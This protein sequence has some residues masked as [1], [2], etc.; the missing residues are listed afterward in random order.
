MPRRFHRFTVLLF[1]CLT[2]VGTSAAQQVRIEIKSSWEGLGNPR[3][4]DI[5]ISGDKGKFTANGRKVDPRAIESLFAALDEPIADKVDMGNCGITQQWLESNSVDA[6]KAVTHQKISELSPKQVALFRG[7]FED[8][9]AVR[10]ALAE[11]FEHWH[12]DDDP[13]MSVS[14][15]IDGKELGVRS[16]SQSPFMLPW[17]GTDKPRG[18]YNC[19]ISQ[20]IAAL[21]PPKFPDRERLLPHE[22][23]R[24]DLASQIMQAIEHE[25]NMLDTEY[26]IGVDVAPVFARFPPIESAVTC[27]MSIDLDDCGWNATLKDPTLPVNVLIGVNLSYYESHHRYHLVGVE[28]FLK[29]ISEYTALMQSVPWLSKYIQAHP[30]STIEVRFVGDRSLSPKA[31]S[32]LTKDLSDHGKQEL[33]DRVSKEAFTSAFLEINSSNSDYSHWSRVIVFPNRDVLLWHFQGD[34]FLGFSSKDFATWDYYGWRST[35]TLIDPNG[36]LE[37]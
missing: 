33:A 3:Q 27:L 9:H 19:R 6:L 10:E 7:K 5:V 15:R 1:I 22:G 8:M 20:S 34:H 29:K 36:R 4:G 24:W 16:E 12:T 37:R 30:S 31:L 18:G 28:G 14:I 25:W 26:K 2:L 17:S 13:R 23:F 35:G 11:L 21:L 32:S